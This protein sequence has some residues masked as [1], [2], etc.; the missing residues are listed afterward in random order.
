MY[1]Y[2]HIYIYIY[3]YICIY[4]YIYIYIYRLMGA[5]LGRGRG[6][7]PNGSTPIILLTPVAAGGGDLCN[8]SPLYLSGEYNCI[9]PPY[10]AQ[11]KFT[12]D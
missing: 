12:I 11:T 6:I 2:I 10:Y 3:I 4:V 1:I 9:L 8:T 7:N 5:E